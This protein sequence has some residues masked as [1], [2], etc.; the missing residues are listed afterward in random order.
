M[1][2]MSDKATKVMGAPGP[3]KFIAIAAFMG[4][5]FEL[6]MKDSLKALT[7]SLLF[8]P[9]APFISMA[10]NFAYV[11][12]AVAT[13]EVLVGTV[14]DAKDEFAKGKEDVMKKMADAAVD[15]SKEK[16]EA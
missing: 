14:L 16:E 7:T 6:A 12:V 13:L 3:F 15:R 8:P 2:K 5:A 1:A 10:F 11:L 4:I 9:A